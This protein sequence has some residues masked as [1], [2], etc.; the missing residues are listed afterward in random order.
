MRSG[1]TDRR[2]HCRAFVLRLGR[3]RRLNRGSLTFCR[4]V[5]CRYLR[6]CQYDLAPLDRLLL[7]VKEQN[8][9]DKHCN[10]ERLRSCKQGQ[11]PCEKLER[12]LDEVVGKGF[13][14]FSRETLKGFP[15]GC[16]A[17]L[18]CSEEQGIHGS[19]HHNALKACNACLKGAIYVRQKIRGNGRYVARCFRRNMEAG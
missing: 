3:L 4:S 18:R 14:G 5:R 8:S 10:D 6:R 15:G 13:H 1:A 16:Q 2:N 9:R 11:G 7:Q 19:A 12:A 17:I